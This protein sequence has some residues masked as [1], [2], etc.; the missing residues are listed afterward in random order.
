MSLNLS[1]RLFVACPAGDVIAALA[2]CHNWMK[3]GGYYTG[4][5]G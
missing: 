4:N 3:K 5:N 2:E 1:R